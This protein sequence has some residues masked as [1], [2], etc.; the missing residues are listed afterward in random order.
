MDEMD[1]LCGD[2]GMIML[3]PCA[4]IT[5]WKRVLPLFGPSQH[6]ISVR[7]LAMKTPRIYLCAK[8]TEG[9]TVAERES[10]VLNRGLWLISGQ[11]SD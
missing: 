5:N 10:V 8:D 1:G 6:W 9:R 3:V 2:L 11:K 7:F 4:T